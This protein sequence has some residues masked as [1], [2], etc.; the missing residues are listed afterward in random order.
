MAANK[1]KELIA[2]L[3]ANPGQATQGTAGRGG[4]SHV[5]GVFFQTASGTKFLR[6]VSRRRA[7]HAGPAVRAD[8]H[9]VDLAASAMPQV[10][11]GNVK[12]YAVT[13]K[14][15]LAAAPDVPTVDK[16]GLPG[17][18]VL[19]WHAI[20]V[21]KGTPQPIIAKLNAAAAAALADPTVGKRLADVG[22]DVYPPDQLHAGRH[23]CLP[24]GGGR[25]MVAGDQGRRDQSGL[26]LPGLPA[27]FRPAPT[28]IAAPGPCWPAVAGR[29]GRAASARNIPSGTGRGV[30]VPARPCRRSLRTRRGNRAA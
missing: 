13:S 4:A 9:D 8:R 7:R 6:A 26:T 14:T 5:A 3:K 25:E 15:R 12:A 19:S 22:Q 18:Y 20:W 24:E 28:P 30:A 11:A 21:P 16:A 27:S 29:D 17:F 10:R 23:A 1:L 2:W